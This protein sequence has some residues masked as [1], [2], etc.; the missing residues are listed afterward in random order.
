MVHVLILG[1]WDKFKVDKLHAIQYPAKNDIIS[2]L[3]FEFDVT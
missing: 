3:L 2:V 1:A